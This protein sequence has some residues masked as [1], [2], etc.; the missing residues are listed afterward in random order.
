MNNWERSNLAALYAVEL[1][2]W[3]ENAAAQGFLRPGVRSLLEAVAD[4][5]TLDAQT[6]LRHPHEITA[7]SSGN[8][9][10]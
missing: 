3:T 8:L 5:C 10:I 1:R 4:N 7:V 9:C 6:G 2:Y